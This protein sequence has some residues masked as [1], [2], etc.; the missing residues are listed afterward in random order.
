MTP[1]PVAARPTYLG[2]NEDGEK[3]KD[4]SGGTGDDVQEE[5]QE[6]TGGDDRLDDEHRSVPQQGKCRH[7]QKGRAAGVGEL[8]EDSNG[9]SRSKSEGG[10]GADIQCR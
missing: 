5:G 8:E 2:E 7:L 10:H 9:Q 1:T 4:E 3:K 6:Q